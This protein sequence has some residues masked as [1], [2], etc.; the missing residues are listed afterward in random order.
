[1]RSRLPGSMVGLAVLLCLAW[2]GV[3]RNPVRDRP[4]KPLVDRP[5]SSSNVELANLFEADQ[6]D[7]DNCTNWGFMD[8][9]CV[10]ARDSDRRKRAAEMIS[11][12]L[13]KTGED[14]YRAAFLFQHGSSAEDYRR[15]HELALKAADLDYRAA[16]WL[17]AATEDRWL[18]SQ[19]K[20]Q[21]WGTQ[22][23][24]FPDGRVNILPVDPAV[25]DAQRVAM[26]CPP[27]AD[28]PARIREKY[29][30]P[31]PGGKP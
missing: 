9:L 14:H 31:T 27:L 7:R 11:Q 1:M 8:Q 6:K 4:R 28:A 22:A 21:K 19:G 13:V 10:G 20:H 30:L 17:A 18:V 26:D 2:W 5:G 25:T 3:P 24:I 29:G 16:R 23:R 15:A 12:G